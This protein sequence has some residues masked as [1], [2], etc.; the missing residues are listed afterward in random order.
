MADSYTKTTQAVGIYLGST[1]KSGMDIRSAVE[2]MKRPTLPVL[3]DLPQTATEGMKLKFSKQIKELAKQEAVLDENIGKLF[4]MVIGQ[5]TKAVHE[6]LK[7]NHKYVAIS[8]KQD[9]LELLG[10]LREICFN[11]QEHKY[12]PLAV[13]QM[14]QKYFGFQQLRGVPLTEYY[15]LFQNI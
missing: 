1:C 3:P 11:Y 10:L 7:H 5:C 13:T 14:K 4:A 8:E 12:A 15:T 9:G 6:R 2:N